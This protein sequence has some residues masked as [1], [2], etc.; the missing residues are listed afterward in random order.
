[1]FLDW[2]P[3]YKEDW[4]SLAPA[5]DPYF[6]QDTKQPEGKDEPPVESIYTKLLSNPDKLETLFLRGNNMT[7]FDIASLC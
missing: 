7:D 2:N 4:R 3:I 5:D 6:A 1:M